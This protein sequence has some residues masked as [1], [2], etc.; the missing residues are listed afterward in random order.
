M[1]LTTCAA[2]AKPLE[3]DAPARC[4]GCQTRYCS[5]RCLRY[6]A[7]RGG[8]DDECEEIA[9]GGGAEQYHADK[10]Y[11][12]A[13]VTATEACAEDTK[14]QTCYICMEGAAEEGLVRG[15]ACR[16]A[17][18][19]A[20]VSCLARQA[21]ILVAEAEE[22]DLD[23]E[24]VQARWD[25]WNTCRLCE[26]RYHGVVMCALGWACWKTYVGR[27]EEHWARRM[28]MNQLAN[29]LAVAEYHED[30]LSV[31]EAELATEERLGASP[32]RTLVTR[33]NLALSYYHLG[34]IEDALRLQREVYTG[35]QILSVSSEVLSSSALREAVGDSLAISVGNLTELLVAAREFE[36]AQSLA[37]EKLPAIIDRHGSD[38]TLTL[39]VRTWYA[40]ALF[41]EGEDLSEP[42]RIHEDVWRRSRR[43][44]GDSHPDTER[45]REFLEEVR[46]ARADAAEES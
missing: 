28:A 22:R 37:R 13:F 30:S 27:P 11:E 10:K 38:H 44:L 41:L 4:V 36:E 15:C 3:H 2:C 5:D 34:R 26:Q 46:S 19:V 31:R 16:G 35:W 33:G 20:H 21:K 6:H 24:A 25:R 42:E 23:D 14:D 32:L 43:V 8:H 1:I 12:E 29:G 45:A 39:E 40:R 7:H 9:N 18:G 17:A